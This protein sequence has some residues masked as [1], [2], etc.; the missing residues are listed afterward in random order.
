MNADLADIHL[1]FETITVYVIQTMMLDS[2]IGLIFH[3]RERIWN[4]IDMTSLY[5]VFGISTLN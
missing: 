4:S 3:M 2:T 1:F 5:Q